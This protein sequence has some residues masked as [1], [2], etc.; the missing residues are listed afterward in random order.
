LNFGSSY[1]SQSAG[2]RIKTTY[3]PKQVARWIN[4]GR[5]YDAQPDLTKELP[6]FSTSWWTWWKAL[7]PDSC[8]GD[9][10]KLTR[11]AQGELWEEMR[12]GSQNGFFMVILTL[13]WWREAAV[14]ANDTTGFTTALNDVSWV[15]D[16]MLRP[17]KRTRDD[18][19]SSRSSK[20]VKVA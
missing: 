10:G 18:D 12:K 19:D 17:G 5:K 16:H 8:I 15:V 1:R 3:R 11:E 2:C 7:Q 20:K 14:K 6:A 4:Y 9:G 13:A